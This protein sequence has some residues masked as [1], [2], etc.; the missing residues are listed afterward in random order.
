MRQRFGNHL[1]CRAIIRHALG[2]SSP[3]D[4]TK[5]VAHSAVANGPL[6]GLQPLKWEPGVGRP[7]FEGL[8]G[9]APS[10]GATVGRGSTVAVDIPRAI[11]AL[12]RVSGR[13]PT[14]A[15]SSAPALGAPA[16]SP[17]KEGRPVPG[18]HFSG[19][20]PASGPFATAEWAASFVASRPRREEENDEQGPGA[21]GKSLKSQDVVGR[22]PFAAS[23]LRGFGT[24]SGWADWRN[25]L[26]ISAQ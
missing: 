23:L 14:T 2:A 19:C 6:A 25:K 13:V 10:A 20:R 4:A 16:D 18:S 22:R 9:G 26:R 17:S 3:C 1:K 5:D 8:S 15:S 12:F 24:T 7:S 21:M 11:S